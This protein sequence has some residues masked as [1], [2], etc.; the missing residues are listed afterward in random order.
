MNAQ[1]GFLFNQLGRDHEEDEHQE[2]DVNH[3][4]Q[5]GLSCTFED[6]TSVH[7]FRLQIALVGGKND[8]VDPIL[9]A[10]CKQ[11]VNVLML[12]HTIGPKD[13]LDGAVFFCDLC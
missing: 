3:G 4:S 10:N 7:S 12:G 13:D 1:V 11:F 2:D 6:I 8:I 9:C 5:I